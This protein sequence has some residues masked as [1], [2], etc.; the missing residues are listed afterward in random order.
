MSYS[1]VP[2]PIPSVAIKDSEQRFPVHRIYCVGRNYGDHVKEMGGN[3]KEEPPIFFSKP[4]SA[5]VVDGGDVRYPQATKDLHHEVELVVALHSGGKSIAI[6]EALACVFAYGVGIDFTRRDLQSVAKKNGRPWD[7]AKGFDDS[8]PISALNRVSAIGHPGDA[9]IFLAVNNEVRQDANLNLMIWS[10]AEIISE[11]S[12]YFELKPGDLI[13]TGTPA[14][15]AA[16]V[17]GD[18]FHAEVEAVA[19]LDFELV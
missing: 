9:R 12:G 17:A 1:F 15:V 16:S 10:V 6:A 19:E 2:P 11:L 4:A 13:Y 5:L 8:A 14:G 7:L 3:P 18:H